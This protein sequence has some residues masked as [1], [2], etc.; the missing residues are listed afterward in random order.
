MNRSRICIDSAL[1]VLKYILLPELVKKVETEC[2]CKNQYLVATSAAF[3]LLFFN[4]LLLCKFFNEI[5]LSV[6]VFF[7][8]YIFFRT[9]LATTITVCGVDTLLAELSTSAIVVKS[10]FVRVFPRFVTIPCH[11]FSTCK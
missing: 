4:G 10:V 7:L 3:F 9:T 5:F 11:A 8:I 1:E 2:D 6:L